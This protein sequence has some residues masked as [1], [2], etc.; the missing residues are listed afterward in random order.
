MTTTARR[1]RISRSAT[2]LAMALAL[3]TAAQAATRAPVEQIVTVIGPFAAGAAG[4]G[5]AW[6]TA[7]PAG[8]MLHG[9]TVELVDGA[10]LRIGSPAAAWTISASGGGVDGLPLMARGPGLRTLSLP[11]PLGLRIEAGDSIAL[12]GTLAGADAPLSVRITIEYEPLADRL[13]RLAVLPLPLLLAAAGLDADATPAWQAPTDGRVMMLV[14]VPADATGVLRLE[15]ALSGETIWHETLRPAG[16]AGFGRGDDVVTIGAPVQAG[17]SYRVT[18]AGADA[19][20][21]G[22][23]MVHVL[24]APVRTVAAVTAEN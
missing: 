12:I 23:R 10:G 7:L 11:R 4:T 3:P 21:A 19:A 18:L 16:G 14:G 20:G 2:L 6:A 8:A 22:G 24:L 13:T 1:I 15:D 9:V 5:F 17:R